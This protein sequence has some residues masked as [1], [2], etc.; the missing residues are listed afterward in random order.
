[1]S[2]GIGSAPLEATPQR[3]DWKRQ[4][5]D[6]FGTHYVEFFHQ[7][8]QIRKESVLDFIT[9]LLERKTKEIT[10]LTKALETVRAEGRREL[11]KEIKGWAEDK[12]RTKCICHGG[13]FKKTGNYYI[14]CSE[15]KG[16]IQCYTNLLLVNL[17]SFL[18]SKE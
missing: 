5:D 9:E 1:M 15:C 18:K 13:G 4:F 11:L 7:A 17:L 8:S 12:H 16:S 3:E 14:C 6:E 2:K 10:Q